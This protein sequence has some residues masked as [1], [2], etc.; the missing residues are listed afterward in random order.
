MW[1]FGNR[2]ERGV[3]QHAGVSLTGGSLF[4]QFFGG[5]PNGAGIHVDRDKALSISA[6]HRAVQVIAGDIAASPWLRIN[7]TTQTR[8]SVD[9]FDNPHPLFPGYSWREMVVAHI[10]FHGNAYLLKNGGKGVGPGQEITSLYPL[11]PRCVTPKWVVPRGSVVPLERVYEVHPQADTSGVESF[12][13]PEEEIIHIP[14][15]GFDGLKGLSV[16]H[17]MAESLGTALAA[18]LYAGKL[19]GSGSMVS[20]VL[21]VDSRL[22]EEQAENLKR[23]WQARVAGLDNAGEIAVLDS[24]ASFE[25][26]TINPNDAQFMQGRDYSVDDV[27]RW[28]GVPTRLLMK[29]SGAQSVKQEAEQDGVELLRHTLEHHSARI[30]SAL[31]VVVP[32]SDRPLIDL[33]RFEKGDTKTRSGAYLLYRKGSVASINEIREREGFPRLEDERADDPFLPLSDAGAASETGGADEGNPTDDQGD[34]EGI[35]EP[36]NANDI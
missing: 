30:E 28:F 14:G 8:S 11:D 26:M 15:L 19:Y 4:S 27:A 25:S 35:T 31:R 12:V 17:H 24:G 29:S 20:G 32:E 10:L 7:E 6:V 9:L 2:E 1:L 21:T 36:G 18:E 22:T 16:I 13:I 34:G 23:R 3:V 5:A 33:A